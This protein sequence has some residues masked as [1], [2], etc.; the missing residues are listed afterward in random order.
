MLILA[1]SC[2][3]FAEGELL[4]STMVVNASGAMLDNIDRAAAALNGKTIQAGVPF[5]FNQ[6]VG[7]RTQ[8]AGYAMAVNGNG[9]DKMGGGVSQ[10]ATTLYNALIMADMHVIERHQHSMTVSYVDPSIDAAIFE[11]ARDLRFENDTENPIYIYTSVTDDLATVTIYGAKPEYRYVLESVIIEEKTEST[12]K[13]YVDD[14]SGKHVYYKDDPPVLQSKG[15]AGGI[16]EGW[17]V[18]YDW[19]TGA[20]VSRVKVS[21]DNY[22]PGAN[23][24][25][26]GIHNRNAVGLISQY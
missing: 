22:K 3:A 26:R 25:W 16:S 18:A 19:E 15:K 10:V 4:A 9:Y 1:L 7:P 13:T 5:S 17:I 20:E 12:R 21:R 6:I 8:Q 11:D 23:V 2:T 24:Y 14:T